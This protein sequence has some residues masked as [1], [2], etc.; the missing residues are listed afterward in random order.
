[1]THKTYYR[2]FKGTPGSLTDITTGTLDY[3]D[4]STSID[5]T[6]S[7]YIYIGMLY[8]TNFLYYIKQAPNTNAS[9]LSIQLWDGSEW[10]EAVD[11]RDGTSSGGKTL[12][13]DGWI[14]WTPNKSKNWVRE[15]T[16]GVDDTVNITGFDGHYIYDLY[17]IRLKVSADLSNGTKEYWIGHMYAEDEDIHTEY[18]DFA[19]SD[20]MSAY[21]S[22]KTDW[23]EQLIRSS[24][25]VTNDLIKRGIMLGE[26]Q[27][28]AKE[29][30]MPAAVARCAAMIYG[31]MGP[32]YIERRDYAM[33]EYF[34]RLN[35]G[36][37][38]IDSNMNGRLDL[39][40]E[41]GF[42][43]TTVLRRG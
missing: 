16:I 22:G 31:A 34:D 6:S 29:T 4:T 5:I 28:M 18:P 14:G 9:V 8:P 35:E 1:M 12:A 19:R 36:I 20:F 43:Q 37:R 32:A 39:E 23:N 33:K 17:W 25:L 41:S 38:Y 21:E 30:F 7:Q 27:V 15:D 10:V 24:E 40:T 11:V 13:I 42:R 2:V 26:G 3:H